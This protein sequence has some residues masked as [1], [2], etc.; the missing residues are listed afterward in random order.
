[1]LTN[2]RLS[3]A[4]RLGAMTGPQCFGA[5]RRD[6]AT[7]AIGAAGVAISFQGIDISEAFP[8]MRR[9]ASCP[10]GDVLGSHCRWVCHVIQHLNDDHKW[11]RE[12]IA[13]LVEGLERQQAETQAV[14]ASVPAE[15]A[16]A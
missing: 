14:P 5:W 8:I 12:Q 16:P 1:M 9:V 11:T 6:D 2:M 13:D 7:C 4:I 3:E 15:G 10:L